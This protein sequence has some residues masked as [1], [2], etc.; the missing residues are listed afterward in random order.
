MA[1]AMPLDA[2]HPAISHWFTATF[3]QPT[4]AQTEAWPAIASGRHTLIAAPTGSGKTLAAFLWAINDLITEGLE[5]G[6]E[7]ETRVL[8]VSPLRALS[9][10]IQKN[11]QAPLAGIRDQLL[12]SGLPDIDVRAEVRT[13]DTTASDRSRM[14]R[15]PP[16]ILVTT[17][18]S[19]YILLTSEGGRD[20]LR[21]V[22]QVIVDEIH[23]VAGSKRGSHLMLSLERLSALVQQNQG[24]DPVRIGIS[25]TQKPISRMAGFLLGERLKKAEDCSIVDSGHSRERE[26]KLELPQSPL[27]AIMANEVWTEVYDR[28]AQLV[29]SH[30][31]TLIFVNTR[32]LA[33]RAAR[34]LAERIGEEVVSTHHGSLAKEHRLD[35][36]QRLKRGEL[37]ALVC[38]ASLELGID[39]GDIDLVCQLGSPRSIAA[40]LQR[41]GRSGHA[42]AATPRG[43]L[44]PL[45]RDDLVECTA[46]LDAALRGELDQIPIPVAPLDVLSQQ[47][48]GEVACQEF[49]Q[50]DLFDVI[51]RAAPYQSL[52]REH[53]DQLLQM[54]ADGYTTRHGRRGAYIHWDKI[55]GRLRGRRGAKLTAVSNAGAIPDMFDSQ[56]ILQPEGIPIGTLNEDFAFE[57]LP[58]DIVQLGNTSYRMLKIEMGKVYVEDAKGQPPNMPFWFGEAP[59]RTD[60]LSEAVSRLRQ[61]MDHWL[62]EGIEAAR[63]RLDNELGTGE[64]ASR[65]LTDYLASTKAMLGRIPTQQ[66]IVFERFFDE[67]GDTHL[68]IHSPYGSRLNRAWGLALRKRF[69]R[70]FNFELQASA[71]EDAIVLSLGP[72]HSFDLAEVSE[73]LKPANVRDVLVQALLDAPMFPTRWRWVASTA[74]AVRRMDKGKRRPPQFQRMESEDLLTL[75]FPDQ[76]ACAENLA[77]ARE[78]PDHPLVQQA[79]HDC[80]TEV[81]DCDGL[82]RVLK[83]VKTG[84]ITIHCVELTT[85]SPLAHEIVNA[86]PYAFLDDGAAEER[87]TLAVRTDRTAS[88]QDMQALATANDG[89]LDQQA[90]AR[91]RDEAWPW[92]RSD[93]TADELHDALMLLGF[94]TGSEAT[95]LARSENDDLPFDCNHLFKQLAEAGRVKKCAINGRDFWVATERLSEF[96]AV[97]PNSSVPPE[98]SSEPSPET[99]LIG[100]LRSRMEGLGPVTETE[101]Q[102]KFQIEP[103]R[104]QTA[105][106]ALQQEGFIMQGRYTGVDE[107]EWCERRLLARIHRYTLKRKRSEIEPVS[108]QVFQRFLFDWQ[109]LSDTREGDEALLA[110]LRQLEGLPCAAVAWESD[111]LPQRVRHYS[112]SML[113]RLCNSGRITWLRRD[114]PDSNNAPKSGPVRATPISFVERG[115][116]SLWRESNTDIDTNLLSADAQ[117]IYSLLQNNG[118][119]FFVELLD[120]SGLLRSRVEDALGELVAAGLAHA[121]GYAG[122]RA[123]IA[124]ANKRPRLAS[125]HSRRSARRGI[126]PDG[127][128]EAGRWSLLQSPSVDTHERTEAIAWILLQRYGV[129]FRKL[130]ETEHNLPAWRELLYVY[131]RLEARGEIRGGRFVNG[132]AGEQY[133]LPEAVGALRTARNYGS[134][135]QWMAITAADPLNLT[136][137]ITAGERIPALAGNRILYRDGR[138]VA[139]RIAGEIILAESDQPPV[140]VSE[141][142]RRLIN[143]PGTARMPGKYS[144]NRPL[145]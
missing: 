106:I 123:L 92:I 85:P 82:E 133:A 6:L 111:I 52:Q 113:D 44:F 7:T 53:Y 115:H 135:D 32:R 18:E 34:H 3:S 15:K 54:L 143:S 30:Q 47:I 10:D 14:R 119:S 136:G 71:L 58:G 131:R 79:I 84:N 27:E 21:T 70:R 37:K 23:A 108:P 132:F 97:Y 2:F 29:Q 130:W 11:L 105:L 81:M 19:L 60:E 73:Y 68:V 57:S 87:R 90:I 134:Q 43:H 128:E 88:P 137:Q 69:C 63:K 26:L 98:P 33:E 62:D 20:M 48:V 75:V 74:L 72:T 66:D 93:A 46:L 67:V 80:L 12:E 42:V 59:G 83:Q 114:L 86:R 28:L 89:Q 141:M 40:F 95:T 39:I 45:S 56:V 94:I 64:S 49:G 138:P 107:P 24:K 16:Q 4:P 142:R 1:V 102:Q 36:E 38:T 144:A 104:I 124:P 101:L 120:N 103:A 5:R 112:K 61:N 22:R 17:P 110:T 145:N 109:G 100:L 35:A 77:G 117:N 122:L 99:A 118:A 13:G 31:T 50:D 140:I 91:V 41:V 9:N 76:V 139:W 25:A 8:Y 125:R 121:D 126:T 129:I 55:N 127:L 116:L 96:Y 65:Q 51:R 78:V